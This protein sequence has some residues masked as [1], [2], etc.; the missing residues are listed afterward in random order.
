MTSTKDNMYFNS[1]LLNFPAPKYA[2]KNPPIKAKKIHKKVSECRLIPFTNWPEMPAI[3]L[4]KMNKDDTAAVC[5]ISAQPKI[6]NIGDKITPPPMP[7]IPDNKPIVAPIARLAISDLGSIL[8]ETNVSKKPN[9]V[10]TNKSNIAANRFL[11]IWSLKEIK[12]PIKEKGIEVMAKG[13]NNDQL[14]YRS[15]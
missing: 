13:Q 4:T 8:L 6:S 3:E 9:K 2:P 11:K 5:L 14:K 10:A 12:D 7:I 15:L 1:L